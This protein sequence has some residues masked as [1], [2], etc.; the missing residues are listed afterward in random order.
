MF[1]LLSHISHVEVEKFVN[2][3]IALHVAFFPLSTHVCS[4]CSTRML[5]S[6]A[7]TPCAHFYYDMQYSTC[8][9]LSSVHTCSDHH[10]RTHVR[11]KLTLPHVAFLPLSTHVLISIIARMFE[12]GLPF[13][14][15]Q[16]FL[17]PHMLI[18]EEDIDRD[19]S[20]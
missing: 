6:R 12:A 2:Y 7:N 5:A 20:G 13:R 15:L 18:E 16:S 11:I 14:M 3:S 1:I 8:W 19:L 4:C 10:P 17:C 9:D